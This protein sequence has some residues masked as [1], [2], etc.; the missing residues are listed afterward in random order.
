MFFKLCLEIGTGSGVSKTGVP[1]RELGN[2]AN[3]GVARLDS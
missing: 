3:G 2:Q 1:K